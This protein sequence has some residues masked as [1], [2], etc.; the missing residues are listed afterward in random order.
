MFIDY[1][2]KDTE[3]TTNFHILL[4]GIK[5]INAIRLHKAKKLVI[6]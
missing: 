1:S 6:K 2:I 4:W 3:M 5:A